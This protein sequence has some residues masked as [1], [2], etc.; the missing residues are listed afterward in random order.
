M[1]HVRKD[2]PSKLILVDISPIM[3]FHVKL[4][5]R[6]NK[7]LINCSYSPHKKVT[8]NHLNAISKTLDS[9]SSTYDKI[10]L[11][12]DFNT[13]IDERH[14]QSICDNYF[15]KSPITQLVCYNNFEKPTCIDLILTKMPRSFQGTCVIETR[16]SDV[17]LMTL[18]VMRNN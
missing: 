1:L 18:T 12:V 5:L 14:M 3:S 9:H 7:W 17:H 4:D 15:L 8:G 10:M 2:I 13:E 11:L 6:N 16:L